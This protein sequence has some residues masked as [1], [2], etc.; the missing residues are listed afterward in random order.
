[1]RTLLLILVLASCGKTVYVSHLDTTM[2]YQFM[3]EQT[4]VKKVTCG[5]TENLSKNESYAYCTFRYKDNLMH[6]AV[7]ERE[8]SL[9]AIIA[10]NVQNE[11]P[12]VKTNFI[13]NFGYFVGEKLDFECLYL[14]DCFRQLNETLAQTLEEVSQY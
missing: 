5:T 13:P 14:V 8:K 9:D 11:L 10:A 12:H 2:R 1:M 7:F 3:L 6:L 4:D